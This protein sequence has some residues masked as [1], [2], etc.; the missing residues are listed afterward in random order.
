MYWE[1]TNVLGAETHKNKLKTNQKGKSMVIFPS[2]RVECL[3]HVSAINQLPFA[4]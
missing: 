4:I 3:I 1:L 2:Q